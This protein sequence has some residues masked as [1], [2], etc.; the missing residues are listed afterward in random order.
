VT[1]RRADATGL[2]GPP[3]VTILTALPTPASPASTASST[4]SHTKAVLNPKRLAAGK[5][6]RQLRVTFACERL[7]HFSDSLV[8]IALAAG[9]ADQSQVAKTFRRYTGMTPSHF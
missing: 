5:T 1:R 2:A 7:R 9:F 4:A 6:V 8:E 3:D